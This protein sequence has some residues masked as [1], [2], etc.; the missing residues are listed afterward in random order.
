MA[1]D[2]NAKDIFPPSIGDGL[3]PTPPRVAN[4][5]PLVL[6]DLL[7]RLPQS[8]APVDDAIVDKLREHVTDQIA[9]VQAS[10]ADLR[11]VVRE[12][13]H[14]AADEAAYRVNATATT[15][16]G[17]MVRW[18]L[19]IVVAA[20][21][22]VLYLFGRGPAPTEPIVIPPIPTVQ[23]VSPPS[24]MM[25]AEGDLCQYLLDE[26]DLTEDARR[27]L[28]WSSNGDY[29]VVATMKYVGMKNRKPLQT[30]PLPAG[31]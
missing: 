9:D 2:K 3:N 5:T 10:I 31:K 19:T 18:V 30:S 8:D 13:P 4:Q 27:R 22:T 12:V 28:A 14:Q 23:T 17:A 16:N 7:H 1:D 20:I 25:I 29:R 21:P 15:A 24:A 26:S 6:Q 11:E